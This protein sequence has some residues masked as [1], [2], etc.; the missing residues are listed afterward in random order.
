[1][2][3]VNTNEKTTVIDALRVRLQTSILSIDI[4]KMDGS[5]RTIIGTTIPDVLAVHEKLTPEEVATRTAI[6]DDSD[7]VRMW[8]VEKEGWRGFHFNQIKN[9]EDSK[10][11]D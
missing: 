8:D 2:T 5:L 1:M 7:L 4:E 3:D 10:I 9:V 6:K 11:R